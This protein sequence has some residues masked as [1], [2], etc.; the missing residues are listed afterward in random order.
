MKQL[1]SS[2][3]SILPLVLRGK[4]YDMI[5]S[6]EKREEYRSDTPY[7]HLRF[8]N[9]VKNLPLPGHLVIA[10]SRGYRKPDLFIEVCGVNLYPDRQHPDWG[11]PTGLH[12]VIAL[13]S[14]VELIDDK[15]E[16]IR[17]GDCL[18]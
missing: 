15:K 6:G 11:E 10:F 8:S 12:Y 9:W 4:W 14:R 17:T 5:A 7:W 3:C 1:K 18:P 2:Q 13:K 16:N